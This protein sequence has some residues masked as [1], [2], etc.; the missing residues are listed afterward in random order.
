MGELLGD[1]AATLIALSGLAVVV[2]VVFI[3]RGDRVWHPRMMLLA[4]V[5]AALFL[6]FYLLKWGLYGTTRYVG[7]EEWRGAY[8]ALL[9]SHTILAALN[10][11]L[12]LWLLYNAFKQRFAIHKAWAR[13]TVPVWLYVAV[14]GWV[15]D[16]VLKRYGESAGGIGF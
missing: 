8:Y 12:V 11:P 9:I 5:L 6:V 10:G 1:I 14:T 3:K 7:P 15:I 4:T 2:G 13:W 16:L